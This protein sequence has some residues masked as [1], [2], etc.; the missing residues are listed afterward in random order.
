MEEKDEDK[1]LFFSCSALCCWE[2]T[3]ANRTSQAVIHYP[4]AASSWLQPGAGRRLE[5]EKKGEVRVFLLLP[6][7]HVELLGSDC[8][9]HVSKSPGRPAMV[10][11]SLGGSL[12]PG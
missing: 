1:K 3:S 11:V 9:S 4:S 7:S 12:S 6:L 10:P 5:G 2:M 8:L